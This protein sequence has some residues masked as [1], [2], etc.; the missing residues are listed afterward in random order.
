MA[1]KC[2]YGV[3]S[4]A[5]RICLMSICTDF[6]LDA[7]DCSWSDRPVP[8]STSTCTLPCS[9]AI[10]LFN[11]AALKGSD[12]I[13]ASNNR[14]VVP[15]KNQFGLTQVNMCSGANVLLAF[16]SRAELKKAFFRILYQRHILVDSAWSTA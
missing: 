15:H 13:I 4:V 1:S 7:L 9:Q 14:D 3:A 11:R 5:C 12:R 6:G 2:S 10:S 8:G 16:G